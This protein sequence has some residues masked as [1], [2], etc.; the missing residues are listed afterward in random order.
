[1]PV[2]QLDVD[3]KTLRPDPATVALQWANFIGRKIRD[4]CYSLSLSLSHTHPYS[5][6]YLHLYFL[7]LSSLPICAN[8]KVSS[9]L[10]I[11]SF[12]L[13]WKIWPT[14]MNELSV[15]FGTCGMA[16][17]MLLGLNCQ[18]ASCLGGHVWNKINNI[19][20]LIRFGTERIVELNLQSLDLRHQSYHRVVVM[21]TV[22]ENVLAD[23]FSLLSVSLYLSR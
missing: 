12:L 18:A 11:F 3:Q 22:S 8:V 6:F 16:M 14:K 19:I 1:M 9:H 17:S 7:S 10:R 20:Y 4:W 23:C 5:P 21:F 2:G 13:I 15:M